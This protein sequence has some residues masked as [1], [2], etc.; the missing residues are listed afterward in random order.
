MFVQV[1]GRADQVARHFAQPLRIKRGPG[2]DG[3]ADRS[4]ETFAD[5]IRHR[6]TQMQI[7]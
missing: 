1:R 4:I 6:V 5:H 2:L 7:D 3:D